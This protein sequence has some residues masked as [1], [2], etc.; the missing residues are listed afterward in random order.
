MKKVFLLFAALTVGATAGWSFFSGILEE[1]ALS[2]AYVGHENDRD[3]QNFIGLYPDAAGSKLDD[4][5][6]CHR[7]GLKGTDTEREFSP[8]GYCH[9]LQYPN[10]KYKTGIPAEYADTL[11]DYGRDYKRN[12]R[13][14]EALDAISH[15]DSDGDGFSNKDEIAASRNPGD[16]LSRPSQLI[17][18][19]ADFSWD[20][21]KHLPRY[22][23]F[24]LLNATHEP[25]DAY[26]VFSGVRIKDLL[27]A[28]NVDLDGASGITVFAPDGYSTDYSLE[29]VTQPFPSGYYYAGAA[30][31]MSFVLYPELIPSGVSD[32]KEI[33]GEL[34]L[35]LAFERD[36]KP[37]EGSIYEKG[38]G[39]LA[40]EGPY[41]LVKPQRNLMG[42]PSKPGRP[43]RSSNAAARN[44]GW[45]HSRDI[46]HNAG[47]CIRGATVI[48]VNPVPKGFEEY[49]WKNTWHLISEKKI[50]IY[51]HGVEKLPR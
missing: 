15:R 8:C 32:G 45:D 6:T 9:L 20:D 30:E 1:R 14:S 29:D 43:D 26:A 25:T 19:M 39:R 50:V 38:T 48:R 22:S 46:D 10:S 47:F 13:T 4:C 11:N 2:K 3:I 12:G 33:P 40:G 17:A 23:Q 42:D 27:E 31:E 51:G 34:W 21:I 36:G 35:L 44:D 28:A 24:M 7:G 5:Q 37:L 18:P 49:D 16:S 41:R